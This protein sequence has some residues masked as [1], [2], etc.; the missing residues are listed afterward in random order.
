MNV[1][2][3]RQAEMIFTLALLRRDVGV[4][5]GVIPKTWLRQGDAAKGA[6]T[7]FGGFGF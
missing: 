7:T 2:S 4:E 3:T 1:N 6:K 5:A